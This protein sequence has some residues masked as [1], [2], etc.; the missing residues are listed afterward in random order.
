MKPKR[1]F[2]LIELAIA[3]AVLI[4]AMLTA[5][6]SLLNLQDLS[7]LSREKVTAL[8]DANRVLEAMRNAVNDSVTDLQS[9]NWTTWA[10][11]N[12]VNTKGPNEIVLNQETINVTLGN[13]NP[14]PMTL[15]VTWNHRQRPY[16]FQVITL[17]T[18]R[19]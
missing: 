5:A 6:F 14:V 13:G 9:T 12:V 1:G 15:T 7:E 3:S 10:A 11:N 2:T 8:T 18:E 4:I 16:T 19:T 17:M